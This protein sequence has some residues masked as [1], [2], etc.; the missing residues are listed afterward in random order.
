MDS[1]DYPSSSDSDNSSRRLDSSSLQTSS[2][3]DTLMISRSPGS[4]RHCSSLSSWSPE[5][6]ISTSSTP[7]EPSSPLA[8]YEIIVPSAISLPTSPAAQQNRSPSPCWLMA[9]L[10]FGRCVTPISLSASLPASQPA[11]RPASRPPSPAGLATVNLPVNQ[12]ASQPASLPVSRSSSLP[13]SLPA[14]RPLSPADTAVPSVL[15]A[16]GLTAVVEPVVDEDDDN[17]SN[18][19]RSSS[20]SDTDEVSEAKRVRLDPDYV[21]STASTSPLSTAGPSQEASED[22]AEPAESDSEDSSWNP[23]TSTSPE[24]YSSPEDD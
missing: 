10:K 7:L 17:D 13:G 6:Q 12:P 2:D 21:P 24:V 9:D 23:S 15:A 14:S 20:S 18:G 4:S 1:P 16:V 3:T 19:A 8:E 5:R 11:S 22:E